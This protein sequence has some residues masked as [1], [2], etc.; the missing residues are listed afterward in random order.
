MRRVHRAGNLDRIRCAH[1]GERPHLGADVHVHTTLSM[2]DNG[3][4]QNAC[5]GDSLNL[6]LSSN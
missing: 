4:D 3:L 2:A 6:A 5:Q 1:R